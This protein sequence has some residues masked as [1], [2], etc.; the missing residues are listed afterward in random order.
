[1][2]TAAV[3]GYCLWLL[4]GSLATASAEVQI[5]TVASGLA[6]P[7]SL[8]FLPDGAML[9][10]ERNGGL[11]LIRDGELVD[12]P[13]ENVPNAYVAGQGGL[14][15]VLPDPD[16]ADNGRVFLSYAYGDSQANATRLISARFDGKRLYDIDVVF[17]AKPMKDTPHHYGGRMAFLPDG[18]LLLTIGD[19]FDYREQ[20][21]QLDNH[22]GKVVR[23]AKDGTPPVDNPYTDV[24]GAL[25]EIYS[26]GHR[27]PQG[28]AVVPGSGTVWLHEHGPRGGDELNRLAAGRNYGWPVITYGRDYSGARISP[29]TEYKGM[30]Q[31]ALY[32][33]PSIAPAGMAYYGADRCPEW[34]GDLFVAALAERS[35][36]R[37]DLEGGRVVGQ[38]RVFDDIDARIR[39]VIV[40]PDGALYLLTDS[41]SGQVLRVT[42]Q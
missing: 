17:T 1:M 18:T 16:F 20:A 25:P 12:A 8:A 4:L 3:R 7:W 19:G 34:R 35:V 31:P 36:R 30:E 9:V 32:W 33:T 6:H 2:R 14:F 41:P 26:Y 38:E 15:D 21:Q 39:D 28:L 23:L 11:R 24:A 37:I 40:G 13:I 29:Y 10:T 5:E 42:C 22:L 27:N